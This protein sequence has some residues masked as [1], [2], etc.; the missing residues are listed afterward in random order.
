MRW[1]S[2]GCKPQFGLARLVVAGSG[3]F[4]LG[5]LRFGI[6]RCDKDG[7]GSAGLSNSCDSSTGGFGS[8]CCSLWRADWVSQVAA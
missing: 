6:A 7:S 8:L 1:A 4:W 5:W 3:W 2:F